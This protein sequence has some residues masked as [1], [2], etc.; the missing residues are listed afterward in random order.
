MAADDLIA[1]PAHEPPAQARRFIIEHAQHGVFLGVGLG[2]AF[3]TNL[4]DLGATAAPTFP[5][6]EDAS[7][8]AED[9][10]SANDPRDMRYI[11]VVAD[12]PQY[13]ASIEACV[14]AGARGWGIWRE[15]QLRGERPRRPH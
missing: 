5:S 1:G 4:D 3:W 2:L 15:P 12:L 10:L 13:Q 14:R 9:F 6:R 8:F 11:E 7:K